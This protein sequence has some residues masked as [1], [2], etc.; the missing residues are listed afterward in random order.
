LNTDQII[1]MSHGALQKLMDKVE[2]LEARV[3]VLESK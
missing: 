1:K 3:A 2:A